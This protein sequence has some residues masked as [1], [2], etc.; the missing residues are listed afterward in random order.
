MFN[1][2]FRDFPGASPDNSVMVGDAGS[3]ILTGATLG[4]RAILIAEHPNY[5]EGLAVQPSASGQ[6]LLEV[7]KSY[8]L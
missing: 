7:V 4:M 2:A 3:D 8:L 1:M 6:S 5:P